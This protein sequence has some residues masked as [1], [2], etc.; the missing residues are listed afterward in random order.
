MHL[1]KHHM[2]IE[3]LLC[4]WK[5]YNMFLLIV[6]LSIREFRA[7]F[8]ALFVIKTTE[9][10]IKWITCFLVYFSELN[11]TYRYIKICILIR[12]QTFKSFCENLAKICATK[13]KCHRN[14][15]SHYF[16][17]FLKKCSIDPN[18]PF[19]KT[20]IRNVCL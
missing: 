3:S 11:L 13:G 17:D 8:F 9:N 14:L 5:I 15:C 12:H 19:R 6:Y 18:G 20:K 7:I 4:H 2:I 1:I 16:C 10:S